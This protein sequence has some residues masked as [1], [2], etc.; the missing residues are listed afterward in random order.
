MPA[1]F[2]PGEAETRPL[3]P[4]AIVYTTAQKVADLLGIGPQEAVLVSSDTTL[5]VVGGAD[6]D[7]AKVY[8]TGS[9]YRDTGF[10][11]GDSILVYSD[12][13]PMGFTAAITEI[14]STSN[15]VALGFIS[16]GLDVSKYQVVDNTYVQNN[17]SFTNGKTRGVTQD[18]VNTHI[19]RIQD[20]ID[21]WTHNAWRPY[22]CVA[23]YINFDT[24]KPYRRRYYTD[25]VGTTPLLYRNVQQMLRIELWQ[26]DNYRELAGAEARVEV[27]DYAKLSGDSLYIHPGEGTAPASLAVGPNAN[28]WRASYDVVTSAQNLADLINKEDRVGK[29]AIDF[30]GLTVEDGTESNRLKQLSLHNEFLATANSDYGSGVLK[31]TSMRSAGGGK[32]ASIA[33]SDETNLSI[34][35]TS[36][37]TAT[38]QHHRTAVQINGTAAVPDGG[39]VTHGYVIGY[40]LHIAVDGVDAT[41][42]LTPGETIYNAKGTVIGI[43][44][45]V[46]ATKIRVDTV[47]KVTLVNDEYIYTAKPTKAVDTDKLTIL[48]TEVDNLSKNGG[49]ITIANGESTRVAYYS[50][51]GEATNTHL[52][53]EGADESANPIVAV[54]HQ[55]TTGIMHGVTDLVNDLTL[56][57]GLTGIGTTITQKRFDPDLG[58]I[59]GTSGDKQRL[60]DWWLDH[61]MGIIYFN[62]S[63]PF[64]EWNAVKVSYIYG[65]RYLEKAI[66]EAATKLVCSELL[67]SDDRSVLIP[68]GTQ[69]VDLGSKIQLWRKEAMDILS[70]YKEIVV[71]A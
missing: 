47:I 43:L 26:G 15:G 2:S 13:D 67:M 40:S 12:A 24:Y 5:S 48:S 16:E 7:V 57:I 8:V 34:S 35:H 1:V 51:V 41:T 71:F 36:S 39:S 66:E 37:H 61:E 50:S 29:T 14:T 32:T 49:L 17:A 64:F 46:T 25:Y 62:N 11:V 55:V 33:A 69:N 22:L 27:V 20:R 68:E 54:A 42:K 70:R 59:S 45:D 21:N 23:E 31:I 38:T 52:I 3:D 19:R 10:S 56:Q 9:D 30:T 44:T 65:E 4:E 28:E 18:I 60:K 6:N 63:Y 58:F 53:G